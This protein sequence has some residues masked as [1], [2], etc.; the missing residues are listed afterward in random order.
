MKEITS[1]YSPH[2]LVFPPVIQ[3]NVASTQQGSY[4]CG[5][6]ALAY[7]LELALKKDP[8]TLIFDQ[9]KMRGHFLSCLEKEEAEQFPKL[10]RSLHPATQIEITKII[11]DTNKWSF[12]KQFNKQTCPCEPE[13]VS[14]Q[15]RFAPLHN[16]I[17]GEN[18]CNFYFSSSS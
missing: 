5:L 8:L 17:F 11:K 14:L 12:P 1:V 10:R 6:F 16:E 3:M 18:I 2:Q 4:D 15:N 7:A 13:G 9:T